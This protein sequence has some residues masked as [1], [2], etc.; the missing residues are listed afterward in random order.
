MYTHTESMHFVDCEGL[1]PPLANPA[2]VPTHK[3]KNKFFD[4]AGLQLP[5]ANPTFVRSHQE[6]CNAVDLLPVLL[7][8]PPKKPTEHI[9]LLA[10]RRLVMRENTVLPALRKSGMHD[11]QLLLALRRLGM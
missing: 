8:S 6:T 3:K 7:L 4:C 10:L 2:A 9:M 5:L 11:N 1:Q